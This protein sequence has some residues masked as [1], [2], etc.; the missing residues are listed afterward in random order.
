MDYSFSA[1]MNAFYA[2][3]L[4]ETLYEPTNTWPHDAVAVNNETAAVYM[5]PTAPA[6]KTLGS[7]KQLPAWVDIPKPT[8]DELIADFEAERIRLL[9]HAD[10]IM[11]DW[12]TELALGE[13]SDI[14]K[15]NLSAWIAYKK[16][17]KEVK[18]ES[19]ISDG[20]QWPPMP[21]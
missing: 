3:A 2:N 10:N 19:I 12:R 7:N 6:G 9:V 4:R 20:V 1:S 17:V 11:A 14:D 15:A 13:I 5:T 21:I 16:L 8:V 18:V